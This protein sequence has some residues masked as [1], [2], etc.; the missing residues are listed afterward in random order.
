[1]N[2]IKS[3]F[4]LCAL[5]ITTTLSAQHI[6]EMRIN[7][8]LVN[9]ENSLVDGFGNKNGWIEMFNSSYGSVDIGGCYLSN[10]P[11]NLK[12]YLIPKGDV[13]TKISPRQVVVFYA[14]GKADQGT[15]YTN[16]EIKAGETIY[17]TSNDGRTIIDQV[18]IPADLGTDESYGRMHIE[19]TIDDTEFERI[20]PSPYQQN[21]DLEAETKSQIMARTDPYGWIVALTSMSVVFV[22]LI[23]L[24]LLFKW[25]GIASIKLEKKG[26]DKNEAKKEVA[27]KPL[28]KG[29]IKPEIA[30]AIAMAMDKECGGEARAAIAMAMHLYLN[31]CVHDEESFVLTITPKETMWSDKRDMQ[32]K[33]PSK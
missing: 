1:M 11:Q 7:E 12:K 8:V 23:I 13:N 17:F 28:K 5:A 29:E 26:T 20:S 4:V 33:N 9:N 30:A 15:Y 14:S 2:K 22:S 31:S 21:G 6:N 3:L 32:L 24:F 27:P 18:T 19:G 16:F 25:I 10:D